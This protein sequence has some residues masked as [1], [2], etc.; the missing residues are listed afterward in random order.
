[1]LDVLC[2]KHPDPNVP[3]TSILP[4]FDY[5]PYLEDVEITHA[6]AHIQSVAC[7][8]QGGAVQVDAM[9]LTAGIFCC[10]LVLLVPG[11]MTL[12][13]LFVID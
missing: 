13:L 4:S 12:L 8:L 9:R 6:G 11:Y 2:L 3:P 10:N 5:L 1:M 7:Q